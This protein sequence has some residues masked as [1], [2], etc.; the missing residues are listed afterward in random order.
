MKKAPEQIPAP[1]AILLELL[2][3]FQVFR[4]AYPGSRFRL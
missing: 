1:A 2:F 3:V 4:L